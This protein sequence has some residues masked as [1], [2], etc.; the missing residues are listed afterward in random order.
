MSFGSDKIA[1]IIYNTGAITT[2]VDTYKT[3]PA[4]WFDNIAP[5]PYKGNDYITYYRAV[6]VNGGLNYGDYK[7]TINCRSNT[8]LGAENIQ[9]AVYTAFNR[10]NPTTGRGLFICA[11]LP[12]IP[13]RDSRDDYN[14]PIEVQFKTNI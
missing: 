2:L 6:P 10:V 12:T 9:G 13:T 4:I 3:K 8:S 1:E 7:Y 14:A 5:E 11:A